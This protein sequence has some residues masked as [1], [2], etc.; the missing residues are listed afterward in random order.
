LTE[1]KFGW[2]LLCRKND[3]AGL[4]AAEGTGD[5]TV[6]YVSIITQ[7]TRPEN[8][9]EKRMSVHRNDGDVKNIHPLPPPA[10]DKKPPIAHCLSPIASF[11]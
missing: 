2:K 4:K 1:L 3:I 7:K 11:L 5:A 8:R 10:G 6:K 9:N